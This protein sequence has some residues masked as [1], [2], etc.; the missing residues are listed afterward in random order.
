MAEGDRPDGADPGD[1]PDGADPE[2]RPGP[3]APTGRVRTAR[4]WAGEQYRDVAV[5]AETRLGDAGRGIGKRLVAMSD[6]V[7]DRLEAAR[8]H[9]PVLDLAMRLWERDTQIGGSLLAAAVAFRFFLFQLPLLLLVVGGL[10][11]LSAADE[12]APAD[13]ARQTGVSGA[14]ASSISE[15]LAESQGG[16]WVA[17]IVGLFGV[18]WA[19]RVFLNTLVEVHARAWGVSKRQRSSTGRI[20]AMFFAFFV[21]TLVVSAAFRAVREAS[22]LPLTASS[23]VLVGVVYSGAWLLLSRFLP[24]GASSWLGLV[25]GAVLVGVS[26]A[27]LQY[28]SHVYLPSRISSASEVYGAI[29]VTVA[30]LAWLFILG[31]LIVTAAEV[32][33]VLWEHYEGPLEFLLRILRIR[34]DEPRAG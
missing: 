23:F 24:R 11:F 22:G 21:A 27:V 9:V 14:L 20:A 34:S 30:A 4:R 33:A 3:P 19:G 17:L 29:G 1:R 18:L 16:R 32:N 6:E 10:G 12:G 5:A 7:R 28:V 31:R 8:P 2:P 25:P 26:I 15:A 13:A